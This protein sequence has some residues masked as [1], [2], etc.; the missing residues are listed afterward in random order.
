MDSL[1]TK[2][3]SLPEFPALEGDIEAGV[4]IVGGGMAGSWPGPG[5]TAC[6][7]RRTA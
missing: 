2:T 1:W 4:L 5:Q 7:W 3:V 6:W